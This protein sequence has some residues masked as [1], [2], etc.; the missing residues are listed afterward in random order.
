[1][2]RDRFIDVAPYYYALGIASFFKEFFGQ[3]YATKVTIRGRFW[4]ET[5]NSDPGNSYNYLQK[6]VLFDK[7]IFLL[8][9]H[10]M[11]VVLPDEFGPDLYAKGERF[12]EGWQ[13]LASDKTLPFYKLDLDQSAKHWLYDALVSV[14]D[15]YDDLGI[16]LSDF[17][18]PKSR[19]GTVAC[20]FAR[21]NDPL[22]GDFRVQFRP[23]LTCCVSVLP[24]GPGGPGRAAGDD[25]RGQ[26]RRD[27]TRLF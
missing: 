3:E 26:D 20:K 11:I 27:T 13:L 18:R 14:N 5:G 15:R 2:D 22:R 19:M 7:A 6:D 21:N 24:F 4:E 10:K 17:E 1:M 16:A 23:P 25:W 12:D 8:V 9:K